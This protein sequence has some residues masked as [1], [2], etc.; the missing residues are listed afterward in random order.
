MVLP[1]EK[2]IYKGVKGVFIPCD[3]FNYIRET[4]KHNGELLQGLIKEIAKE[5]PNIYNSLQDLD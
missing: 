4:I 3:E 2:T 5:N 1:M